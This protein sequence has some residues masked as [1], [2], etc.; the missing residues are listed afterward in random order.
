MNIKQR[1]KGKKKNGGRNMAGDFKCLICGKDFSDREPRKRQGA[2]N[3]H[4]RQC[5]LKHYLADPNANM[6]HLEN[7][8]IPASKECDHKWRLLNNAIAIEKRAVENG[9]SEVCQTC[10]D[11]K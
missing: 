7:E 11:I 1:L 3:L 5:M 10:Q 6:K 2:L 4:K 8:K 9:Y